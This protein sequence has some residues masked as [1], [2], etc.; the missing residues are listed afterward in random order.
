MCELASVS[1]GE[2]R[3]GILTQ[4]LLWV[5]LVFFVQVA[6]DREF[7]VCLS[8]LVWERTLVLREATSLRVNK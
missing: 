1:L 6:V 3:S 4:H 2:H 7:G 8:M 5:L